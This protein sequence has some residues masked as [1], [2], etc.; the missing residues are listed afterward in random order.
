MDDVIEGKKELEAVVTFGKLTRATTLGSLSAMCFSWH[1]H[2]SERRGEGL[3]LS[4]LVL[5]NDLDLFINV[6]R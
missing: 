5:Y 2:R 3:G 1:L 4:T 6:S